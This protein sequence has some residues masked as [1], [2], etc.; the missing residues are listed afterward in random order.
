ME[1]LDLLDD[2]EVNNEAVASN[3][4]LLNNTEHGEEEGQ[5]LKVALS[6][7]VER[8]GGCVIS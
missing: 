8:C 1:R 2:D 5:E 3:D 6:N 4:S 7:D